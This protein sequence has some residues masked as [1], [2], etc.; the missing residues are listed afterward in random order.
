[1]DK[2]LSLIKFTTI[3]CESVLDMEDCNGEVFTYA[4]AKHLHFHFENLTEILFNFEVTH[5]PKSHF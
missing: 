4:I 2:S 1:M 3:M 5:P